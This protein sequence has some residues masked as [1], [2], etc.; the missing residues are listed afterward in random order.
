[1][2]LPYV[3]RVLRPDSLRELVLSSGV[4]GFT[5]DVRLNYYRGMPLSAIEDLEL[6]V[7]GSVLPEHLVL[8]GLHE[9]LFPISQVRLAFS[10]HWPIKR[11]LRLNVYNGGLTSGVHQVDLTL[12]LRNVYM[13]F[14]PGVWGMIDSS[15]SRQLELGVAV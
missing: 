14:A 3:D 5:L 11:S 15:A 12:H 6:T 9:K 8:V 7:D 13:H 10:E 2:K 1:M 4:V